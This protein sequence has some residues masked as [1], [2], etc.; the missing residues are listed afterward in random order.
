MP[1]CKESYTCSSCLVCNKEF[2]HIP[3][4]K[5]K[6]CGYGCS[7]KARESKKTLKCNI[8]NKEYIVQSHRQSKYCSKVCK[9]KSH[10]SKIITISCSNC[11]KNFE[12][13]EHL[14]G[15]GKNGRSFCS[16]KCA[17]DFNS[18]KNHYEWKE[19]LHDK[20]LKLALTQWGKK[21]KER[22]E[23]TCQLCRDTNR[24]VLEAHH[25]KQRSRFPEYQFD[26]NNGITLCLECHS[27]QHLNDLKTYRLI[28]YKIEKYYGKNK[29]N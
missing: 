16:K 23:Y 12:I 14:A 27:L 21:I 15:R 7:K 22:D 4:D 19:N 3:S 8:C 10:S 17:T 1:Y 29:N 13:K 11:N 9:I 18:G 25:I 5:R 2:K 28:K 6:Y 26:F 24:G 20:H